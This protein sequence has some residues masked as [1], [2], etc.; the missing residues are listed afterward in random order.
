MMAGAM[1]TPIEVTDGIG[2]R[3]RLERTPRRI[4]SLVPST[5]ESLEAL[6]CGGRVVG[7]T[8]YCV[9]PRP[10]V[11]GVAVIGGTKDPDVAA[12]AALG[13]DLIV[14]NEEENRPSLWPDLSAIA[15]L[16]VAYPRT[17]DGAV[18]DLR[19]LGRL[20]GAGAEADRRAAA[21]ASL[22]PG[23]ALPRFRFVALVWRRPWMAAG[24]DTF[25]SAVLDEVG[26]VN[27]LA[28]HVERYPK[29][30]I[31]DL[32]AAAP[33]VILLPTE[34]YPFAPEHAAELGETLA[35]RCAVVDGELLSWHGVRLQRALPYLQALA[36][37]VAEPGPDEA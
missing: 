7:R 6:G 21:I 2:R 18:A 23:V 5:T 1:D 16:Y 35:P 19:R 15:P 31:A 8:R 27:A 33:D 29:V 3:V 30:A 24:G 17:L 20:V 37:T 34:P 26:G 28:G 10:W 9:H 12:I 13:P 11:D 25:I 36:S 14:A 32:R 22:R 4:V